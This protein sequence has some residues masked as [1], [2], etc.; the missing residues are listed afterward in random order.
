ML[1]RKPVEIRNFRFVKVRTSDGVGGDGCTAVMAVSV[2][3]EANLLV[4]AVVMAVSV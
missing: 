2:V 1:R 3:S 4:V